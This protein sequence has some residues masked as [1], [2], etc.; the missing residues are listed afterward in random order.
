MRACVRACVRVCVCVCVCV[1]VRVR[2]CVCEGDRWGRGG[3]EVRGWREHEEPHEGLLKEGG[4]ETRKCS[5]IT[6]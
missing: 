1:C 4:G 3:R 6:Y 5:I 2:E